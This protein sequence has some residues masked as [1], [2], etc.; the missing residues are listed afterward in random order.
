MQPSI[1]TS[2]ARR[3]QANKSLVELAVFISGVSLGDFE[4]GFIVAACIV[5]EDLYRVVK[6]EM[7]V[8]Y[9]HLPQ[10]ISKT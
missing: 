1:L 5:G 10:R 4:R 7:D 3:H 6:H 2:F 9:C 8:F